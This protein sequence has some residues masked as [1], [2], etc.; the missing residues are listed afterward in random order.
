MIILHFAFCILNLPI[1]ASVLGNDFFYGGDGALDHRVVGLF[2]GDMLEPYAG[3]GDYAGEEV[4]V[5][6][7]EADKFVADTHNEG[8]GEQTDTGSC[9]DIE[10]LVVNES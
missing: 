6:A 9:D 2:C 10:D 5:S 7:G 8:E 1:I 3:G 4:I